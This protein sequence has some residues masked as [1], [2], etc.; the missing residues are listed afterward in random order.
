M[1]AAT[2]ITTR[3]EAESLL[4]PR[5]RLRVTNEL[6][7]LDKLSR[8]TKPDAVVGSAIEEAVLAIRKELRRDARATR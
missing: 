3:D 8:S 5:G 4:S 6:V 7:L 2:A 1:R